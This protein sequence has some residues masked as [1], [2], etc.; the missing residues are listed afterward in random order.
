[1]EKCKCCGQII[2][3]SENKCNVMG[4]NNEAMWEGWYRCKDPLTGTP[5]GLSQ[6]RQV[7]DEHKSVLE[8][9]K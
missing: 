6:L 8:G 2:P 9:V 4:C 3:K 5:S 7:C 1:M